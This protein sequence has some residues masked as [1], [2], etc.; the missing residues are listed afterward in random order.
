MR[1]NTNRRPLCRRYLASIDEIATMSAEEK[2]AALH[3]ELVELEND[4]EYFEDAV[5][6]RDEII[7]GIARIN[8][9]GNA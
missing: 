1:G 3:A 5:M 2:L 8:G 4:T 7:A 9:S 6:R